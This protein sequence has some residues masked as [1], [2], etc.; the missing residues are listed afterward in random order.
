MLQKAEDPALQIYRVW[1]TGRIP[2][3]A[4]HLI[5]QSGAQT[6]AAFSQMC[7]RCPRQFCASS[8][9]PVAGFYGQISLAVWPGC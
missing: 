1:E 5:R 3:L 8:P 2:V 9:A 6:L 4:A 7:R